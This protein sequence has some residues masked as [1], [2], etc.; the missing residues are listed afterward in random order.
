M[1][2]NKLFVGGI[3]QEPPS[4]QR[5]ARQIG[6]RQHRRWP[7]TLLMSGAASLPPSAPS[8]SLP[9]PVGL[10]GASAAGFSPVGVGFGTAASFPLDGVRRT[11]GWL[12]DAPACFASPPR[13]VVCDS[14]PSQSSSS[15][16]KS[17]AAGC[18]ALLCRPPRL[19]DSVTLRHADLVGGRHRRAPVSGV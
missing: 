1:S 7:P 19:T 18:T 9:G 10:G 17:A 13:D 12:A 3:D 5:H 4:P 11:P 8:S 2:H 16:G 14:G 15:S 6:Q